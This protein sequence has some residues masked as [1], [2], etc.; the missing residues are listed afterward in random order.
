[1]FLLPGMKSIKPRCLRLFRAMMTA[2]SCMGQSAR[3]RSFAMRMNPSGQMFPCARPLMMCISA[4]HTRRS[5]D[6]SPSSDA[7]S[8][9]RMCS[10][11]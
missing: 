5:P 10:R 6:E 2:P 3:S 11:T 8:M 9:N 7:Y 4:Y 1:M